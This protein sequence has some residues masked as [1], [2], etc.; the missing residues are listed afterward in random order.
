[1][2]SDASATAQ[3][4]VLRHFLLAAGV[5]GLDEPSPSLLNATI[6]RSAQHQHAARASLRVNAQLTTSARCLWKRLNTGAV[7]EQPPSSTGKLC[8]DA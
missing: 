1:M 3:L 6:Q 2:R 8:D 4:R 5:R 7:L